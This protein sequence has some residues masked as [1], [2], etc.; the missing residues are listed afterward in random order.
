MVPIGKKI[1]LTAELFAVCD[2][3]LISRDGKISII[4]IFDR[5]GSVNFPTVHPKMV[6]AAVLRGEKNSK[7]IISLEVISPAGRE[8]LKE[9]NKTIQIQLTLSPFGKGNLI[10][11]LVTFRFDTEGEYRFIL[12][13]D[14]KIFAQ[15]SVILQKVNNEKSTHTVN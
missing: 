4:G 2:Y 11:D 6:L 3:T 9:Q 5:I 10:I 8:V 12:K 7:L 14:N 1:N 15:T 13:H